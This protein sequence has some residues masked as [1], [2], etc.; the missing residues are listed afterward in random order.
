[1]LF[2]SPRHC[3]GFMFSPAT[4]GRGCTR[5]MNNEL[6]TTGNW[7]YRINTRYASSACPEPC[8]MGRRIYLEGCHSE[9]SFIYPARSA[10]YVYAVDLAPPAPASLRQGASGRGCP[11][12]DRLCF[13]LK[14]I[15]GFF[16]SNLPIT[17][18][19]LSHTNQPIL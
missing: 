5:T 9:R 2:V 4:C 19:H 18:Y 14:F 16:S 12:Q 17:N 1:M 6:R 8:R 11:R 10:G 3:R 7:D 15:W 13:T